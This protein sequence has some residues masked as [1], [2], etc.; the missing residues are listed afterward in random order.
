MPLTQGADC[1]LLD[2]P[3]NHLDVDGVYWLEEQ[4]Q[5]YQGAFILVSHDRFFLERVVGRIV[6][7]NSCYPDGLI[8][9]QGGYEAFLDQREQFLAGQL[10]QQ[11]RLQNKLRREEEW[12]RRQPKARTTKSVS[13]IQRAEQMQG[14]LQGS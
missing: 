3:T 2:E 9:M 8:S 13:R 5:Q 10:A 12:L 6:E 1:L 11:E 7:I 14:D 4:L